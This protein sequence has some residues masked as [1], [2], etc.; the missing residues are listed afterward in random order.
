MEM[1][2]Q[3]RGGGAT[4]QLERQRIMHERIGGVR[5]SRVKERGRWW[6]K[7]EGS[8]DSKLHPGL[9]VMSPAASKVEEQPGWRGT[10]QM[11]MEEQ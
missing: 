11:E 1:E 7:R 10:F 3:R 5:K 2:E 9:S 4:R 8:R 6:G